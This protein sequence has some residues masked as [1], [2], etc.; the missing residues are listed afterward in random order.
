MY[1]GLKKSIQIIKKVNDLKKSNKV[2]KE[3]VQTDID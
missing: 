3:T 1:G 2:F